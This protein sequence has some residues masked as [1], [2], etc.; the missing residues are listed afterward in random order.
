MTIRAQRLP[1]LGVVLAAAAA[2]GLWSAPAPRRSE[3]TVPAYKDASLPIEVRVRDLLG[4]MTLEEKAAQVRC[5]TQDMERPGALP[6]EGVGGLAVVLRGDPP[7][8][9]AERANRLQKLALTRTRLGIPFLIHDE[10]LHGIL[11]RG[12]TS[13]PQAIGLAATWNPELLER[14][15]RAIGRETRTRGIRQVLSPVVNIARDV[16]WGRTEET[17]GED[18]FLTSALG[19]AFCRGVER[20]GV[21]TTPKHYV[22]NVGDGGRDSNPIHFSERLLR[23]VYFPGFEACFKLGGAGSV[24]AAYNSLNGVPC[25]A[26][27]WLLTDIL[28]TEWGFGGF[29]VS[30]YG[31]VDGILSKHHTAA[32]KAEAAAQAL[33]AGLDMELP[34]I[35]VFGE[36]LLEALRQGLVN[37]AVLDRSVERIL[38]AKFRLG[39]FDRPTV[40]PAAA[41]AANDCAENRALALEAA[42]QSIVLL[43]NAGGALPLKAGLKTIAV[44]GPCAD[45]ERLGGYSGTGMKVVTVLAGLRNRVPPGTRVLYAK[46]CEL[47]SSSLPAI[48]SDRLV[49]AGADAGQNGLKGEYFAN[50]RLEGEPVVVRVDPTINFDWATGSPD[51]RIPPDHFSVRWTGSLIPDKTQDYILGVTTDDG[52]RFYLD[53]DL[54][55]DRWVQRSA[56]TDYVPVRLEAGRAYDLRI[57]YYEN[58]GY[59]FAGLGWDVKPGIDAQFEEA[60]AAARGADVAVVVGGLIEGEGRDRARLSLPG[61]QEDLIKAVAG[62]GVPTVVVLSGGSAVTMESWGRL[63][64]AIVEAW[65]AGEEGGNA[66]ADVLLGHTNPGGRLPVTF[67][68]FA[69]Q[70]PLYNDPRPTGRGWDY[71]DLSGQPLFPFGHGLSYTRFEYG[72]LKV[73]PGTIPAVGS[74]TISLEVKNAG[75]RA[76]DEVVQLYLRDV[77]SSVSRPIRELKGFRRISL[78]PGETKTVEFVLGRDAL[79]FLDR[80]LKPVVEPG[81]FEVMVGSSSEDIRARGTFEVVR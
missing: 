3:K 63:V 46:G 34:E 62:T 7:R 43:K 47:E 59:A 16:R 65:Y 53:G 49:P 48:P 67:P 17:Y 39:L 12:G 38:A 4:R 27:K 44:L 50:D 66:V 21:V 52:V 56:T 41:E 40:D 11:A 1:L 5:T 64:P 36:P 14:V 33:E 71:V 9:G 51:P 19:A 72:G 23:E 6:P 42:R 55:L 32:T 81:T 26:D 30:D 20:E 13:F 10:A 37:E 79:S 73:E 74:V 24:M 31:S 25:S 77:V 2:A 45:A 15:A 29:V 68:Q 61:R 8:E 60:V 35:D 76:G 80:S 78:A 69:G 54:L 57:E 18:P 70:V 75:E 28:R 58:D 22:A